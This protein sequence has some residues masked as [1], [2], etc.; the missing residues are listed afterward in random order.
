MKNFVTGKTDTLIFKEEQPKDIINI[1]NVNGYLDKSGNIWLSAEDVAIGF[2]FTQEKNGTTYVRWETINNYL[3][4][5]GFSQR[6]GKGSFIPESM[7][8]RLGFKANNSVAVRFQTVLAE[9]VLPSI[10]K[11]GGYMVSTPEMSD[12]EIMARALDI[13]H[14]TIA[15]RDE[16]IAEQELLI[17]QKD[18]RLELQQKELK[19]AAPKVTFY[20][21]AMQSANTM[22]TTQVAK[23]IGME[24]NTLNR[25]LRDLGIQYRQSGMW[26]VCAPYSRWKL[27]SIRTQTYTHSDGSIGTSQY[28]VWYMRGYR[29]IV[30]LRDSGWDVKKAIKSLNPDW[31]GEVAAGGKEVM[32]E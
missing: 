23:S 2:G 8:Y 4:D 30:A 26:I 9:E 21:N 18:A 12:A 24:A 27:H 6:V 11:T 32:A 15:R 10:R 17:E 22:T 29:F 16:R 25:K 31:T 1:S 13:A 5:F 3:R 7:V 28:T 20:D 14:A 19:V